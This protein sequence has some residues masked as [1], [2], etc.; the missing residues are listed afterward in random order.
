MEFEIDPASMR[1]AQVLLTEARQRMAR[2]HAGM[3]AQVQGAAAQWQGA[4]GV[5][6]RVTN[7]AWVAK[8]HQLNVCLDRLADGLAMT[9]RTAHD[10]DE[11][12]AAQVG[13]VR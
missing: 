11:A 1:R 13:G 12:V 3:D 6:F 5:A 9:E 10:V 8:A 2:L 4:G 7:T